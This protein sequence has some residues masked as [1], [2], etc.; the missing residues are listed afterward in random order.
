MKK[1]SILILFSIIAIN[2]NAQDIAGKWYGI[3][4]DGRFVEI[5]IS[6][7]SLKMR[8]V[9]FDFKPMG[10]EVLNGTHVGLYQIKDK[11]LIIL[12]NKEKLKYSAITIFNV[13][14]KESLEIA[15][16]GIN[17]VAD[18][19]EELIEL[20]KN[21]TTNL[22]AEMLLFNE[23]YVPFLKTMKN[24]DLMSVQEFK[25][26]LRTFISRKAQ[27]ENDQGF[28]NSV[29][30]FRGISRIL[31]EMGYSPL[32]DIDKLNE[33]FQKFSNDDEV[34]DLGKQLK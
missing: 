17:K 30:M 14:E 3:E 23:H 21:D 33:L 7:D 34:K 13:K 25:T 24:V 2:V 20:S 32:I 11:V 5:M 27:F 9:D 12:F 28:V 18:T 29:M 16:D 19:K 26:L 31:A 4:K 1:I 8:A 15:F 22:K 10:F 6:G